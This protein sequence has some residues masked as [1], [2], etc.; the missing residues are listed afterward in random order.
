MKVV[1][2]VLTG[3][4]FYIQVK[5][6]ATIGDLKKEI[7]SQQKLSCDRMILL[8][9]NDKGRLMSQ[10]QDEVSLVDCGVGQRWV[11]HLPVFQP[12]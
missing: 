8:L 12:T 11:S 7:G 3:T 6:D 9:D 1:V 2:E 10:D 4:L 5:N